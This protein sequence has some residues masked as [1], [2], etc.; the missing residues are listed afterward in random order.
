MLCD[1]NLHNIINDTKLY[2]EILSD[3]MVFIIRKKRN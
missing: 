3:W 1:T 2:K